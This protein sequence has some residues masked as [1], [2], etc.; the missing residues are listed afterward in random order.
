MEAG[1][2]HFACTQCGACCDRSPEVQLSEAAPLADIF[3]FRLMFRLYWLPTRVSDCIPD[4]VE[5]SS[6]AAFYEKKRL[7]DAFCAR[8]Y[9]ARLRRDGRGVQYTKYLMISALTLDEGTST[10][11][12]LQEKQ[13]SIYER[14]PSGCRS[15]PFHYSRGESVAETGL[16]H[17]VETQGYL[18]DTSHSARLVLS[19]DAATIARNDLP[20][21][22][23]IARS[24]GAD[25]STGHQLPSLLDVEANAQFG[26]ST[27]SMGLAWRLAQDLG[28]I[29]PAEYRR[30]IERQL[31]L[32]GQK[33][34]AVRC[35]NETRQTLADMAVEYRNDLIGGSTLAMR[36]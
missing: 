7:L 29:Q 1:Q 5:T 8:K 2:R 33:L 23:A 16:K 34:G 11:S 22:Q 36:G 3:V 9:R 26:A 24:M 28:L 4:D 17:F 6:G 31:R 32:I 21:R 14:R 30:L 25:C 13:C 20:W 15:V 19:D 27:V 18:C 12:A 35:S 10:C